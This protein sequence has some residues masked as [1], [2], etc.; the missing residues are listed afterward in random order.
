MVK[1]SSNLNPR[2]QNTGHFGV[3]YSKGKSRVILIPVKY[4]KDELNTEH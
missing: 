3:W 2:R 1:L 4:S